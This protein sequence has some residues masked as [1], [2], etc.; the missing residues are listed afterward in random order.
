MGDLCQ[1][2]T[3]LFVIEEHTPLIIFVQIGILITPFALV[4]L[5]DNI[6][7]IAGIPVSLNPAHA[8]LHQA[9]RKLFRLFQ[10]ITLSG[11]LYFVAS[12]LLLL[13]LIFESP[14]PPSE[15][16]CAFTV[17]STL[18]FFLTLLPS[19]ST[20]IFYSWYRLSLLRNVLP[21]PPTI[22]PPPPP[23]PPPTSG[24]MEERPPASA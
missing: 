10:I 14:K 13:R 1:R 7:K 22:L 15:P 16:G 24:P 23:A 18:A 19:V 17:I 2:I 12:V 4:Q 21:L 20:A 5:L 3:E 6:E 11:S 9:R 8:G